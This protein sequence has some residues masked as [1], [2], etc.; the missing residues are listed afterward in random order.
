MSVKL[1]TEKHYSKYLKYWLTKTPGC[2]AMTETNHG[3]NVKGIETKR[4]TI[5][6]RTFTIHTPHEK[7]QKNTLVMLYTDKWL[8]FC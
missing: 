7:A 6:K 5:M 1:G 4:R 3:S 2:F 8:R